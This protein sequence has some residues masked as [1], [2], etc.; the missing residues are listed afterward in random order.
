[1]HLQTIGLSLLLS[2]QVLPVA[3]QDPSVVKF[4]NARIEDVREGH[5]QLAWNDVLAGAEGRYEVADQQDHVVYSG[6]QP[7]AF[8][9]G[10]GDGEHSFWVRVVDGEGRL[11]ARV[12]TPVIVVVRHWAMWQAWLLFSMGALVMAALVVAIVVG[13]RNEGGSIK[14]HPEV[15]PE[16]A[17]A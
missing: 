13:T 8:V 11:L 2:V 1:M 15:P 17:G 5:V 12:E 14:A 10:L 4:E 16:S 6:V 9:S 3:G 7:T